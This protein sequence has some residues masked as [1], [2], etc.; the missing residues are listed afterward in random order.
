MYKEYESIVGRFFI[1]YDQVSFKRAAHHFYGGKPKKIKGYVAKYP[2][3]VHFQHSELRDGHVIVTDMPISDLNCH[4]TLNKR[5]I[6]LLLNHGINPFNTVKYSEE[7]LSSL[8]GL[9]MRALKEIRT[10]EQ[11]R[12]YC[13]LHETAVASFEGNDYNSSIGPFR[14]GAV[15]EA[16]PH[17][18]TADALKQQP[19]Q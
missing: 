17:Q 4:I 2:S 16:T 15:L 9:G 6:N 5:T 7:Y 8:E 19:L 13:R 3:I 18:Y 12:G 1:V 11:S 14:I 10:W